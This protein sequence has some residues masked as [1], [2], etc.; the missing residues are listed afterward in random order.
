M[1]NNWYYAEGGKSVG[2]LSLADMTAT[3][4]RVSNGSSVLVWRDGLPNWVTAGSVPE[5]ATRIIKPPPLPVSP[6]I[7]S[8]KALLDPAP[9]VI[10]GE[11]RTP[12]ANKSDLVGIGG[13]LII[14]A[15]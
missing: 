10:V 3:L 2:P 13:W 8:Q 11:V 9:P 7:S 6:R 4:S 15:I 5:L 14:V 1:D 12:E